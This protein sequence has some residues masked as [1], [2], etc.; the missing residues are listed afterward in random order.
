ML[1]IILYQTLFTVPGRPTIEL[2]HILLI[3][4]KRV[5]YSITFYNPVFE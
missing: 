2:N 4:G 5:S 1:L 3:S